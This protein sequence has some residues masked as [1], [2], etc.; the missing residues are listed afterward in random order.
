MSAR[1]QTCQDR[2]KRR[3]VRGGI[4]VRHVDK[5]ARTTLLCLE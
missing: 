2:W 5:H 3:G 4:K 1:Q